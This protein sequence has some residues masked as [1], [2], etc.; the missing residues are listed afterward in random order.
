M[1]STIETIWIW[2]T[3][4]AAIARRPAKRL[5]LSE[6]LESRLLLTT[7][8]DADWIYGPPADARPP[9]EFAKQGESCICECYELGFVGVN[10]TTESPKVLKGKV[11][12]G[13][14]TGSIKLK[15][16]FANN[17]TPSD[18]DT[19]TGKVKLTVKAPGS[20]PQKINL[21]VVGQHRPPL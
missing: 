17:S 3:Q 7:P 20:K 15:G 8:W 9:Q 6:S 5:G 21:N 1:H 13:N 16:Q 18:G 12:S 4:A 14:I 11:N 19:F 10:V 2:A